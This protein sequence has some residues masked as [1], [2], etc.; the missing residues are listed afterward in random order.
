MPIA[1]AAAAPATGP[2][3]RRAS[4]PTLSAVI[5]AYRRLGRRA[6]HAALPK[7]RIAAPATQYVSGG[8][9][10]KASPARSGTALSVCQLIRQ[11]RS[12]SRGS[13]GVQ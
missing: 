5:S 4:R 12:A 2:T 10:Q 1:A 6:T 7:R 13:S 9:S 11:A 3:A 8:F